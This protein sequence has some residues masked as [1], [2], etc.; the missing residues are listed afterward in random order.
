[1]SNTFESLV[2]LD[3]VDAPD[4]ITELGLG[5]TVVWLALGRFD[6]AARGPELLEETDVSPGTMYPAFETLEEAGYAE[7]DPIVANPHRGYMYSRAD[8]LDLDHDGAEQL[9]RGEA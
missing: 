1:M 9:E 3:A 2:A 5:P 8:D 4:E 6:D 7:R